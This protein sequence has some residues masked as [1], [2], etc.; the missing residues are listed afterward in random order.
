MRLKQGDKI[1][2]GAFDG[3]KV[4]SVYTREQ[5]IEDGFLVDVSTTAKEAGFRY[6]V[7]VTRAVWDTYIV[8]DEK[9]R[10]WGQGE[11]GRLWDTLWMLMWEI[12]QGGE[13]EILYKLYFVMKEKQRRLVT[14]K[15]VCGPGDD[16][17]PVI[18]I[19]LPEED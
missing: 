15:A 4:I 11:D 1:Q 7:A 10:A 6:P 5:A 8:P 3:F 13:S 14:L 19:M 17:E 16:G 12:R 2:G 18:T 9:A